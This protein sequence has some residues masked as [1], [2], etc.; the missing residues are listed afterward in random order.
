MPLVLFAVGAQGS[1]DA[2]SFHCA[3]SSCAAAGEVGAALQLVEWPSSSKVLPLLLFR[4]ALSLQSVL[5]QGRSQGRRSRIQLVASIGLLSAAPA[6]QFGRRSHRAGGCGSRFSTATASC[7]AACAM[8]R[9][10]AEN[11]RKKSSGCPSTRP[12]CLSARRACAL[13]VFRQARLPAR[14]RI[15]RSRGSQHCYN[16]ILAP[17]TWQPACPDS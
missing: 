3:A 10:S 17:E 14:R 6:S 4:F 11:R 12:L 1:A 5:R 2:L 13:Q 16:L 15:F 7:C 9:S 8:S